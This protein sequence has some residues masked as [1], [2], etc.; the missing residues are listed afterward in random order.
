MKLAYL[1]NQYPKV[2]HTFIRREIAALES[3]GWR[4]IASPCGGR[5][6][7]SGTKPTK[8][9][10]GARGRSSTRAQPVWRGLDSGWVSAGRAA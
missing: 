3:L 6:S 5:R 4:S 2:S 9:N 7:T 10:G 1:V 8:P